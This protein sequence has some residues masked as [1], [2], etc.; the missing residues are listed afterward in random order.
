MHANTIVISIYS[1][2]DDKSL[3]PLFR[4][5]MEHIY[6]VVYSQ[7]LTSS[8]LFQDTSAI[9]IQPFIKFS[10]P[11]TVVHSNLISTNRN[12]FCIQP[13]IDGV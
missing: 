4:C 5:L 6:S 1:C 13:F 10:R 3:Q 11:T 7:I 2:L 9:R 12:N 8:P